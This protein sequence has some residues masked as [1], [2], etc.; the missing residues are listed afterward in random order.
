M[1]IDKSF[2]NTNELKVL[3]Y[4]NSLP[5]YVNNQFTLNP[6][7]Y[8]TFDF[9]NETITAELKSRRNAHNDYP[10]TMIGY[11][12]VEKAENNPDRIYQFYFLFTDGL[13]LWNRENSNYKINIGGRNDRGSGEWKPYCFI[14]VDELNLITTS[15][16]SIS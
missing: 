16:K 15:I 8:D 5:E 2:G 7:R 3:N 4:L 11:N 9:K 12:K 13:Y 14:P 1:S 10:T 6:L